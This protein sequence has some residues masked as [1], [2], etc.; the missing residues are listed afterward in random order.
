[1][2]PSHPSREVARL[3]AEWEAIHTR[4]R[5]NEQLLS[6]AISLYGRG[7]GPKPERL[8]SEV[9]AMRAEC[10]LRFQAMMAAVRTGTGPS[11]PRGADAP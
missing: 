6:D 8:L 9:V 3:H 7:E 10:S 4:L 2:V 1:M 11:S 5:E